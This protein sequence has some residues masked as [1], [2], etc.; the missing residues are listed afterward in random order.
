MWIVIETSVA[1]LNLGV[2]DGSA[3]GKFIKVVSTLHGLDIRTLEEVVHI[4]IG[5]T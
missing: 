2:Y 1:V 4:D 5:K 3:E